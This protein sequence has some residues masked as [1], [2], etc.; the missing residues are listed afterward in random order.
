MAIRSRTEPVIKYD[1]SKIVNNPWGP[2]ACS[3]KCAQKLLGVAC[4]Y[5]FQSSHSDQKY[6][7]VTSW[8]EKKMQ[9]VTH[10]WVQVYQTLKHCTAGYNNHRQDRTTLESYHCD[11][12]KVNS[13]NH[14]KE[15]AHIWLAIAVPYKMIARR[16]LAKFEPVHPAVS[17]Q[18]PLC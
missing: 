13:R 7:C 9:E 8:D 17:C 15:P 14:H 11:N 16:G 10:L 12:P 2:Q 1:F 6:P 18:S 4:L 3:H 5:A